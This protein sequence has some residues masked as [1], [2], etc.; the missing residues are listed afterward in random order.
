ME[1]SEWM[2]E[3]PFGTS[4]D[5]SFALI[6]KDTGGVN[7]QERDVGWQPVYSFSVSPVSTKSQT[8]GNWSTTTTDT[9]THREMSRRVPDGTASVTVKLCRPSAPNL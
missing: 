4:S 7:A 3:N 1:E 6:Y 5:I 8:Y 2:N 9:S